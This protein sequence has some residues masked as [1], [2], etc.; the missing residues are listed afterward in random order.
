MSATVCWG[1]TRNRDC[2]LYPGKGTVVLIRPAQTFYE[3]I[4]LGNER[5]GVS[6]MRDAFRADGGPLADPNEE[7]GEREALAHLFAGAIGEMKNPTSHRH[8]DLDD[9]QEAAESILLANYLYASSSGA[10]AAWARPN[11]HRASTECHRVTASG[12]AQAS[13]A[14]RRTEPLPGTTERS[15]R[16]CRRRLN[17]RIICS[18]RTWRSCRHLVRSGRTRAP[19]SFCLRG[20]ATGSQRQKHRTCERQEQRRLTEAIPSTEAW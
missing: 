3:G 19:K 8:V 20:I 4:N 15:R 5:I 17:S 11:P 7:L 16:W 1:R 10:L 13:V 9:P 2:I 18:L 12:L 6:L 14:S